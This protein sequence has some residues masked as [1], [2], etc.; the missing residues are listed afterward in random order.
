VKSSLLLLDVAPDPV[1]PVIGIGGLILLVM[2]VLMLAAATIIGFVFFMK[3]M[4]RRA[5]ERSIRKVPHFNPAVQTN[6]RHS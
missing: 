4:R 3:W 6:R 1:T 5:M 2:V